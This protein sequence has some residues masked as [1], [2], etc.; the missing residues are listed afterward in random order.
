MWARK[1]KLLGGSPKT[2]QWNCCEKRT[3]LSKK[4]SPAINDKVCISEVAAQAPTAVQYLLVALHEL[5][6][7]KIDVIS[8][9][10]VEVCCYK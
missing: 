3:G 9:S 2:V 1:L 5:D 8:L 6:G 4:A 10:H 7:D